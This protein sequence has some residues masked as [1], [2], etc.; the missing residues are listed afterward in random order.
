M[1]INTIKNIIKG[2]WHEIK[3]KVCATWGQIT[4]DE[5][6]QLDGE[7]EQLSGL[8]EK[9]YGYTKERADQEIA[10]FAKAHGWK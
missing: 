5:I 1:S 9:K 6:A 7:A 8:I 2:N 4:D 10:D 3:G